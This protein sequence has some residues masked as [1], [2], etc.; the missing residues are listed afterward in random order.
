MIRLIVHVT[1]PD[2]TTLLCGE[3]VSTSPD[4]R[5]RMHG[6]F[7][8]VPEYLK[9]PEAFPLDPAILPLTSKEF[10]T[11]RRARRF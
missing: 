3:M 5:G 10:Q 7:R 6:A 4:P 11:G 1:L 2:N 8:Y 9:H